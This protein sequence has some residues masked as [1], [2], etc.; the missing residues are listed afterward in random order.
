MR[1]RAHDDDVGLLFGRIPHNCLRD[2]VLDQDLRLEDV[3]FASQ[4]VIG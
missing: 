3:A 1:F 2:R 4:P